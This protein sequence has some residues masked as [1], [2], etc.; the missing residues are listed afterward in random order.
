MFS[1]GDMSFSVLRAPAPEL[2][3]DIIAA[4]SGP[5]QHVL[6]ELPLAVRQR[7]WET[8]DPKAFGYWLV[9]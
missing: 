7:V 1:G 3:A 9:T 2:P 8:E 6:S 4:L 5:K